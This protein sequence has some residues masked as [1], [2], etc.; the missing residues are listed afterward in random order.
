MKSK[1][2]NFLA[3]FVGIY[4]AVMLFT[5]TGCFAYF[6]VARGYFNK[7]SYISSS[8]EEAAQRIYDTYG[9]TVHIEN[10]AVNYEDGVVDYDY[11]KEFATEMLDVLYDELA[12][13]ND[14]A[15]EMMYKDWYFV[16]SV[17]ADNNGFGVGAYVQHGDASQLVLITDVI[18]VD[19]Q[20]IYELFHHE[21]FHMLTIGHWTIEEADEFDK[22]EDCSEISKYACESVAEELAEAWSLEMSGVKQTKS[23]EYL[24]A[25]YSTRYLRMS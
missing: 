2:F 17:K 6:K 23:G 18:K 24:I 8:F 13:Y 12:R 11:D 1:K 19:K 22:I 10:D 3:I 20:Y 21:I 5:V 25:N 7:T 16:K 9:I 4:L 15:V 14:E